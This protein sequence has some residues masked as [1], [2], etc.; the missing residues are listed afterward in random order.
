MYVVPVSSVAITDVAPLVYYTGAYPTA[1]LTD[2]T[3]AAFTVVVRVFMSAPAGSI[4]A[5]TL[6]YATSWST[7]TATEPVSVSGPAFGTS[8]VLAA[9]PT[10]VSLWW[11]NGLGAQNLY[12]ISVTFTPANVSQPALTTTRRIGFRV[13]AL[14]TDDDTDPQ[15]IAGMDGSGNLTMRFKVNGAN[16]W[17]RGANW[18]PMV[19]LQCRS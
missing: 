7:Q 1:P 10:Q 2:A 6:S 17:A 9:S 5:G 11:P 18:I 3:K 12:N 14:V 4:V 13:F 19:R 8:Y 16:I 15:K